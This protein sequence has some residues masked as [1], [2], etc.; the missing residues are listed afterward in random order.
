LQRAIFREPPRESRKPDAEKCNVQ[1]ADHEHV[2]SAAFREIFPRWARGLLTVSEKGASST[3]RVSLEKPRVDLGL[4]AAP[5][6]VKPREPQEDL[7][8]VQSFER[9]ADF[10]EP[11]ASLALCDP[12]IP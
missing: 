7:R 6:S 11:V 12:G 8:I 4:Q 5:P 9:G 3:P 1:S 10:H 2:K